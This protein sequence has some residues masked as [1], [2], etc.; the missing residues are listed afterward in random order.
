MPP[1]CIPDE[2]L[3]DVWNAIGE[4]VIS[5]CRP[6]GAE[7]ASAAVEN[8][9]AQILHFE[10]GQVRASFGVLVE[11]RLGDFA[12]DHVVVAQFHNLNH[13]ALDRRDRAGD[14]RGAVVA[15]AEGLAGNL[16]VRAEEHTSELQSLT[17]ISYPTYSLT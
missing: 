16:A 17:R 7:A 3:C 6:A 2:Q 10:D 4:A 9:V 8:V 1:D 5:V 13:L 14:D 15:R 11:M 12:D